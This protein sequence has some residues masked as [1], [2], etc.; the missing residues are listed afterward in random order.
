MEGWKDVRNRDTYN[1][2]RRQETHSARRQDTTKQEASNK[3]KSNFREAFI[4][5]ISI[6]KVICLQSLFFIIIFEFQ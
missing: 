4:Y 3:R 2:E 5:N 1:N 6:A